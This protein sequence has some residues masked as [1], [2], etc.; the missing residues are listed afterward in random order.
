M[1][2]RNSISFK[3]KIGKITPDGGAAVVVLEGRTGYAI[4]DAQTT[5]RM[6]LMNGRGEFKRNMSV[7][8]YGRAVADGIRAVEVHEV[9]K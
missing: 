8:G 7:E 2:D 6:A 9:K 4:I 5:G 1:V 3:G